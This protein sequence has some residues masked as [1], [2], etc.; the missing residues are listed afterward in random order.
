MQILTVAPIVRGAL[1]GHLT[2]F[3]KESVPL[4][5]VIMVP[6][7]TREVPALVL[8]SKSVSDAKS[9]LKS[10]EYALRKITRLKPHRVWNN[11]F[12]KA[13]EETARYSAQGLGETLLALTPKTILDAHV[14]GTLDEATNSN[15]KKSAS[16]K[17]ILAIQSD[18]KTRLEAYRQLVR[19]SFA[20]HESVF[21]CVP[22]L[23][24]VERLERELGHG[25]K[26]Y[27]YA[28][29]SVLTKKRL[30][31]KWLGVLEEKHPTLVIGTP[32]YLA[33][34]RT[35][36]TI[37]LDEENSR[38]WKT[39]TRPLIDMRIFAEAY[40]TLKGSTL[41]F[42]ASILR[43]ETH[44]RIQSGEIGEF[45]R[46]NNRTPAELKTSIID[47][48]IEE[49]HIR[50]M[51]GKRTMQIV[52]D[53]IQTLVEDAQKEHTNI[54]LLAARKGLSPITACGDCGTIIRCEECDTPLVVH[55]QGEHRIFS[56]HSCGLIRT[57]ESGEHETC[58]TCAG[59]RLEPLGIGIERIEDEI[60]ELFPDA[61]RFVFDGDRIKTRAQA[62][63]LIMQFEASRGG[64]LIGTPMT[65]PYL[66]S[67][68]GT[69][70]ISIDSLFAIPDFRMNERI[71]ALILAL[72][73]KTHD[74]LL[75]QTRM[76][77]TTLL[78]QALKGDL[79]A[80]TEA[81]LNLRKAFSYPP[82]GTIIKVTLR[83]K[84]TELPA[85]LERLK[86]YL[87]DYTPISPQTI[88]REPACAGRPK[89]V[90]RMHIILKLADG[91]WPHD[92]L[93]TKLRALPPQFTIEVN[94]DHL[95]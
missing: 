94:P 22:T 36:N 78:D 13:A 74:T 12:M 58:P 45:N 81:E 90:F 31:E 50:E 20:R 23:E 3:T 40:A 91:T 53:E 14:D 44:K 34:P 41:I 70:V 66:T 19:E 64:I 82:Y 32:Q 38:S 77:H 60:N 30:L 71:F 67:V 15:I 33:L 48:R 86:A 69:A 4:G 49:K 59:W 79:L 84:R 8:E 88:T 85:E 80:F 68:D 35:F 73:E 89:N 57:P 47:P 65:V 37:V 26:E 83:G 43:P 46:I 87:A 10:S 27:T 1:Q 51:T 63:K 16:G 25:I 93:L 61:P 21:I 7:R 92:K 95:L 55:K 6:V 5:A 24:E 72:R 29:H 76:D 52:G 28:F 39:L 75:V 54:F 9:A 18:N 17:K 56:C 2:Y 42:G 11:A 62:R